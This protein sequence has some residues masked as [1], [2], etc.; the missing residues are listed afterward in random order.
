MIGRELYI[1]GIKVDIDE[2]TAIGVTITPYNIKEPT[3][4]TVKVSNQFSVPS[5]IHNLAVLGM[6]HDLQSTDNTIYAKNYAR[7]VVGGVQYFTRNQVV[8]NAIGKDRI[9]MTLVDK[10]T[11]LDTLANY[12]WN[13][14]M[15]SIISWF[16]DTYNLAT[17][18]NIKTQTDYNQALY[19]IIQD[20]APIKVGGWVSTNGG[21]KT[22]SGVFSYT[23]GKWGTLDQ[24][25]SDVGVLANPTITINHVRSTSADDMAQW[26]PYNG[27][28][29]G[30]TVLDIF[31]AIR[32]IL[33]VDFK[34]DT[35]FFGNAFN[36][37]YIKAQY[38]QDANLNLV[39]DN[40]PYDGV[41]NP[42]KYYVQYTQCNFEGLTDSLFRKDKTVL[43][44]VKS[45]VK[46]FCLIIEPDLTLRK[47]DDLFT[48]APLE[49]WSAS[50]SEL[51]DFKPQ[52]DNLAQKSYIKFSKVPEGAPSYY[53]GVV[54][55]C[56]N[57][58]L[59]T[60]TD[61]ISID[62]Y[63][64]PNWPSQTTPYLN[65]ADAYNSFIFFYKSLDY[66]ADVYYAHPKLV[67]STFISPGVYEYYILQ[68]HQ[69]FNMPVAAIH[70]PANS[71]G[72][73]ADAM[74][75]PKIYTVKLWLK[76]DNLNE[77]KNFRL[78]YIKQLG[79]A[80]FVSKVQNTNIG[81]AK[82]PTTVELL[83]MGFKIPI[84]PAY[85]WYYVDFSDNPYTDEQGNFY[86]N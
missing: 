38:I 49:D 41:E 12:K 76:N 24:G 19:N 15:V 48:I 28:Y 11:A 34:P 17:P 2:Q 60:E 43:D 51:V 72:L 3:Q 50:F 65:N 59:P 45:F 16:K 36:D 18:A 37:D 42:I 66:T 23:F 35:P 6:P 20:I 71:F 44:F 52:F 70:T 14:F 21:I 77:F 62:G 69:A 80:F 31:R 8:I 82:E 58:N 67:N 68:L 30:I 85:D 4:I 75:R 56:D 46:Q 57:K 33:G 7:Y 27:A 29:L 78:V 26:I 47:F 74:F 1:N 9:S 55:D 79:G 61:L 13:D 54:I 84:N 5:T 73:Y 39:L 81:F 83:F 40:S 22:N 25:Y 10:P 63:F 64:P 86:T 32:D 53:G